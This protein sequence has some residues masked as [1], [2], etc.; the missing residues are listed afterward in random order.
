MQGSE[1]VLGCISWKGTDFQRKASATFEKVCDLINK[2]KQWKVSSN[3]KQA[4]RNPFFALTRISIKS[5][6][7]SQG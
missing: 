3:R 2:S 6:W 5:K 1:R 7:P 4:A